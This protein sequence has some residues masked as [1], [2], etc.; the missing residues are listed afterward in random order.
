LRVERIER[1]ALMFAGEDAA[2]DRAGVVVQLH[3]DIGRTHARRLPAAFAG[4]ILKAGRTERQPSQETK[5]EG[6]ERNCKADLAA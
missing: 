6:S 3:F 4:A 5:P 2:A 1:R